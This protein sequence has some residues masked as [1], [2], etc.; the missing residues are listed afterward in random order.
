MASG[1]NRR[2]RRQAVLWSAVPPRRRQFLDVPE[3][4]A[5]A[6]RFTASRRAGPAP[7][8]GRPGLRLALEPAA[9]RGRCRAAGE[10]HVQGLG[11]EAVLPVVGME[12]AADVD[13][14]SWAVLVAA[15]G[16]VGKSQREK[17]L[18]GTG[19]SP[20]AG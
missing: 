11:D 18:S 10:M 13:I 19:A 14:E 12:C 20:P 7:A 5:V 6:Q 3:G 8:P 16:K 15:Q 9:T 2:T 1:V 17:S 4:Q